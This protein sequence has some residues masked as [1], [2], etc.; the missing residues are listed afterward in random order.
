MSRLRSYCG[1]DG[2]ASTRQIVATSVAIVNAINP[3]DFIDSP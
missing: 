3:V 2:P 1:P